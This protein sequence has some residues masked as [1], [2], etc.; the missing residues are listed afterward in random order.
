MG[1]PDRVEVCRLIHLAF[2]SEPFE[3]VVTRGC[4]CDECEELQKSLRG[5]S[6][7]DLTDETFEAQFGG[8]PL[9]SP[10]AFRSFL[11]AWLVRSLNHLEARDQR[12]REWTLYELAVYHDDDDEPSDLSRQ[13]ERPRLR[14]ECLSPEQTRTVRTFLMLVEGAAGISE[15]DRESIRRALELVWCEPLPSLA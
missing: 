13:T 2:P 9:L 3:G 12:I 4:K 7:T 10:E 11:P 15:W 14:K 5:H 1:F 8:L 6:W